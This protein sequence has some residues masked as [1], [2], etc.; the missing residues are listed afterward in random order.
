[1]TGV[2]NGLIRKGHDLVAK[3]VVQ[4]TREILDGEVAF[5]CQIRPPNISQKQ[6]VPRKNGVGF[7]LFITKQISR[8]FHGVAR[9]VHDFNFNITECQTLTVFCNVCFKV[10]RSVGPKNDGGACF[11]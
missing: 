10:W 11:L 7:A 5:L 9:S 6:G 1:M 8:T 4:M 2:D 3:A